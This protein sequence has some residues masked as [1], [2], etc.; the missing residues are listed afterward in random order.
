MTV[1]FSLCNAQQYCKREIIRFKKAFNLILLNQIS[2]TTYK[3][4]NDERHLSELTEQKREKKPRMF[5]KNYNL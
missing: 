1:I 5:Y 3:I 2:Q 4:R